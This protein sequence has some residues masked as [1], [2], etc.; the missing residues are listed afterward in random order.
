MMIDEIKREA[1]KH[2]LT[3]VPLSRTVMDTVRRVHNG[4]RTT[5]ELAG[6]AEISGTAA[7]NRL[8]TAARLGLLEVELAGRESTYHC[9]EDA[10]SAFPWVRET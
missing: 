6:A 2:G 3:L 9:P 1:A 7:R 10:T 4:V 8:G 5:R